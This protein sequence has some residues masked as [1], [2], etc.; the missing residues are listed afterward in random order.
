MCDHPPSGDPW[1]GRGRRFQVTPRGL[2]EG[3]GSPWPKGVAT[4][5][6]DNRAG[7]AS[8]NDESQKD[9][10][11]LKKLILGLAATAAIAAPVAM[12]AP[13]NAATTPDRARHHHARQPP[14]S[15]P[16]G[17]RLD[18][19]QT[20]RLDGTSTARSRSTPTGV[21]HRPRPD[22]DRDVGTDWRSTSQS[23][24]GGDDRSRRRH[25]QRHH[26][27]PRTTSR[28]RESLHQRDR[29]TASTD[30]RRHR[31]LVDDPSYNAASCRSA[32]PAGVRRRSPPA[33]C[34]RRQPRRVRVRRRPR[35]RQGQALAGDRQGTSTK[36]GAYGSAT[37]QV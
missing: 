3:Q 29:P 6:P 27:R 13:A 5:R 1:R 7:T 2:D 12:A 30:E 22:A 28:R 36:V 8:R 19:V 10:H 20:R 33:P 18:T 21:V 24:D 34:R 35:R 26:R 17:H 14:T 4:T 11:T 23:D 31:P 32:H 15:T 37:C 16:A 25:D 9:T